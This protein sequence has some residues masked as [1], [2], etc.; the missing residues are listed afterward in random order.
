LTYVHGHTRSAINI[1][2]FCQVTADAA[3]TRLA[4]QMNTSLGVEAILDQVVFALG[5]MDVMSV[6]MDKQVAIPCADGAVAAY[7]RPS[8]IWCV[9]SWKEGR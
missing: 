5:K 1:A 7:N 2:T 9:G 8:L 3:A 6:W 4:E